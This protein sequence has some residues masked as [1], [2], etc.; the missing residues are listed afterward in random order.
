MIAIQWNIHSRELTHEVYWKR[1]GG[2]IRSYSHD[3]T[4]FQDSTVTIESKE[5]DKKACHSILK[6]PN[7]RSA[8]KNQQYRKSTL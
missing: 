4:I 8:E 6:T 3:S 2:L 5:W 1:E 7:H